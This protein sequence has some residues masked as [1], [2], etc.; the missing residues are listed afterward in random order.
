M[1]NKQT[2]GQEFMKTR[3]VLAV[4]IIIF[5]FVEMEKEILCGW[6]TLLLICILLINDSNLKIKPIEWLKLKIFRSCDYKTSFPILFTWLWWRVT[7]VWRKHW[8]KI[9]PRRI[10]FWYKKKSFQA[11][12]EFLKPK[13][14]PTIFSEPKDIFPGLYLELNPFMSW[15]LFLS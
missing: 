10:S 1:V 5:F 9:D 2:Y 3:V 8:K 4:S 7:F 11:K 14:F 13:I 12:K 15:R 6:D